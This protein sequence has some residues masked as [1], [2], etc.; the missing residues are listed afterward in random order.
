ML[1]RRLLL[2]A[3]A[4]I[5]STAVTGAR[6]QTDAPLLILVGFPAGGAIDIAARVVADKMKDAL[7]RPVVIEN[8]PGAG[9]RLAADLLKV[10]APDG[11]TVMVTPLV[12]PVLAPMVFS[13]L[14]YDPKKDF[15]PVG[16]VC[17]Y[18]FAVAASPTLAARNF[19]ELVQWLRDHPQQ[20][21]FGSPAAGSLPHFFGAMLGQAA[22]VEMVHVP[23]AGGGALQTAIAGGQVP[24][25][26]DVVLEL[27]EF[28]RSGRVKIL[29]TSGAQRSKALPE[30]PTFRE[31]GY[32]DLVGE[33]WFGMYAPAGTP[34]TAIGTLNAALNKA[35][36]QP[37]V[38]ER[39]GKLALEPMG[40][41][42]ADLEARTAA[43][44]KRWGP[45]V[46]ATGF[47]GD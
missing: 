27:M 21:N 32:T 44:I 9:G 17:S 5:S 20:A 3:A 4:A 37:E 28:H 19:T 12:V 2:A 14:N 25:G 33:G 29:A 8:R 13:K 16:L 23:F 31:A 47:R 39:F 18:Q 40:G 36:T 6:A 42:P 35:L 11:N 46:K 45:V 1:R 30:V 15:A 7:K 24:I 43:D 10:A 26:V 34:T 41:P 22:K 38:L